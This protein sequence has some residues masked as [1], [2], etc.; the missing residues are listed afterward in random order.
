MEAEKALAMGLSI[1]DVMPEKEGGGG[2]VL[3]SA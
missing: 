3:G 2:A 1:N